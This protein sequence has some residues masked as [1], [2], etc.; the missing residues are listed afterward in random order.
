VNHRISRSR[1]ERRRGRASPGLSS[2]SLRVS[3][4]SLLRSRSS[5]FCNESFKKVIGA[6]AR[7]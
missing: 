7:F 5:Q 3:L 2:L 4:F 1:T 6:L